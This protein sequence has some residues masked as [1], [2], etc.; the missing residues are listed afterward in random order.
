MGLYAKKYAADN[1]LYYLPQTVLN[2]LASSSARQNGCGR[3]WI[4]EII[5]NGLQFLTLYI[6]L[7]IFKTFVLSFTMLGTL[8]L[9]SEMASNY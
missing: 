5:L 1:L 4:L 7:T 8:D 2:Y 6:E 9:Y 3:K